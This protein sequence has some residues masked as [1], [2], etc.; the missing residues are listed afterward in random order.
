L[1][2]GSIVFRVNSWSLGI[3]VAVHANAYE[4][5]GEKFIRRKGGVEH[6][7]IPFVFNVSSKQYI[8]RLSPWHSLFLTII[9]LSSIEYFSVEND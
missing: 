2:G 5:G 7:E 6:L 8:N 9:K 4:E 1:R 3:C